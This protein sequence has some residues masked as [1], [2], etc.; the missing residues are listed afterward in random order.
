[1]RTSVQGSHQYHGRPSGGLLRQWVHH[2]RG[3]HL[4]IRTW[5]VLPRESAPYMPKAAGCIPTVKGCQRRGR[6]PS[7][8][9]V[10]SS[11][12]STVFDDS[13]VTELKTP[14]RRVPLSGLCALDPG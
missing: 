6:P 8:L 14:Y 5:L 9:D 1:M 10:V 13:R 3:L 4:Y 2:V 11:F 12:R 7:W